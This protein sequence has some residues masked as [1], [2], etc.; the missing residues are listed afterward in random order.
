MIRQHRNIHRGVWLLLLPLLLVLIVIF[1]R[2]NTELSPSNEHFI[3]FPGVEFPDARA[4][5]E[6]LE[7]L[8]DS[9][10]EEL[11]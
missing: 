6:A 5:L 11:K 8:P 3:A 9:N 7:I 2:P 4:R 1:A 10:H